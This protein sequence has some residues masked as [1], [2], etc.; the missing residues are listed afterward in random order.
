M[1]FLLGNYTTMWVNFLLFQH[2]K[3]HVIHNFSIQSTYTPDV[4]V[5][6]CCTLETVN[7]LVKCKL[8]HT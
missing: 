2:L 7:W 3:I 4:F 1:T 8:L 6:W 5:T